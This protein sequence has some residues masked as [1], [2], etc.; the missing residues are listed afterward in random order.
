MLSE[1]EGVKHLGNA[2][3]I[4]SALQL[5]KLQSP[6]VVIL[7]IHLEDDMP[8]ASGLNLLITLKRLYPVMKVIIL[9]NLEESQYL[10]T[11]KAFGADYFFN[12]TADFDK[13][14]L[15]LKALGD[16]SKDII[17]KITQ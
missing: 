13:I 17:K 4:S 12:K 2:R 5:I 10:K 7:D 14:P 11:C 6:H 8:Q 3:N 16:P 1:I 9:T 15:A